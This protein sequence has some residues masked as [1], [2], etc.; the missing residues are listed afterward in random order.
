MGSGFSKEQLARLAQQLRPLACSREEAGRQGVVLP[1]EVKMDAYFQPRV[2]LEVKAASV[3]QSPLYQGVS[4]R[5][6]RFLRFRE[7]KQAKDVTSLEDLWCV[8]CLVV[9]GVDSLFWSGSSNDCLKET[10]N[11]KYK[12]MRSIN[13]HTQY[14]KE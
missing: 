11:T 4:L 9:C 13:K 2:V 5:F 14:E 8:C 3:S 6:P 10:K 12:R 1:R 7:D